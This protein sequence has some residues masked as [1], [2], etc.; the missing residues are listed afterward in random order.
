MDN[1][2]LPGLGSDDFYPA[3]QVTER[4][5]ETGSR[6][7]KSGGDSVEDEKNNYF[8]ESAEL[9]RAN[10]ANRGVYLTHEPSNRTVSSISSFGGPPPGG[11]EKKQSARS[12]MSIGSDCPD[13]SSYGIS[14]TPRQS[15]NITKE[16][17]T[18]SFLMT[19]TAASPRAKRFGRGLGSRKAVNLSTREEEDAALMELYTVIGEENRDKLEFRRNAAGFMIY[20]ELIE[21]PIEGIYPS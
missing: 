20:I 11:L 3:P 5:G 1:A 6:S 9:K 4:P 7:T 2:N 17:S 10:L 18:R 12:S 19:T 8:D 13:E 15:R 21:V 16:S 14:V